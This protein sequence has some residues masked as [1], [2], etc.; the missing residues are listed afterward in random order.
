MQYNQ[1]G[2]GLINAI[3]LELKKKNCVAQKV[4]DCDVRVVHKGF[5][6]SETP[7]V[8]VVRR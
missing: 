8:R 4:F 7:I 6:L 3:M 1:C 5:L 2:P